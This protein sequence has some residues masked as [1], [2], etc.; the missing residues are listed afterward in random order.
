MRVQEESAERLAF[1]DRGVALYGV[2]AFVAVLFLVGAVQ[3]V[4]RGFVV[5]FLFL[6]AMPALLL[7][8]LVRSAPILSTYTFDRQQ[9]TLEIA[10]KQPLVGERRTTV[11]LED[12]VFVDAIR[13]NDGE[14]SRRLLRIGLRSGNP[15]ILAQ[16]SSGFEFPE[17][18]DRISQ[19]L[20]LPAGSSAGAN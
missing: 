3:A 15:V 2:F 8:P 17:L 5:P 19:F 18:A 16:D 12:I 20:E 7:V 10:R 9:G 4:L 14:W 1:V 6:L 11:R 13:F